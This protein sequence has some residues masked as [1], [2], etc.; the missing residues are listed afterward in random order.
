VAPAQFRKTGPDRVVRIEPQDPLGERDRDLIAGQRAVRGE[1]GRALLVP[2]ADDQRRVRAAVEEVLELRLDQRALFLDHHDLL[3]A[4]GEGEHALGLERPD[5]AELEHA[6]AEPGGEILIDAEVVERLAQI[7]IRLAGRDD[8]KARARAVEHAPIERVRAGERTHRLELEAVQPLLLGERRVRPADVQ[9]ARRRLEV[10]GHA[11]RGARG[12]EFDRGR[13]VDRVVHA[14]QADPA[15]AVAGQRKAEQPEL[16]QLGDPRRVDHRDHRVEKRE[17]ALV[18]RGRG[19]AGVIVAH[20]HQHAAERGGAGEVGVAE[21]VAGAIDARPLAVPHAEH[22]SVAALAVQPGLLGAPERGRGK[23]LV[24]AWLEHDVVPLEET[25]RGGELLVEAA[26][27]RAAVA[28]DVARGVAARGD[29]ARA[30]Q[31]G[32]AHQRLDSGQID[33]TGLLLVLVVEADL[34]KRHA[35]HSPLRRIPQPTS[36]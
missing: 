29:V 27:R 25:P 32:Q 16:E 35:T 2:L 1:Q 9:A 15:A 4:V 34:S 6:Q 24:D 18:R 36:G 23:V 31:H 20:A 10:V 28:A 33:P 17:L 21:G 26:E 5:Q 30:L 12:I 8:A 19:L 13:R 7:Q 22:A 3:E 14:L 11:D